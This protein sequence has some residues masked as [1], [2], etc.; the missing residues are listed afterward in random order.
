M[1]VI[2]DLKAPRIEGSLFTAVM[3]C[4]C[5]ARTPMLFA[6]SPGGVVHCPAC[7]SVFRVAE[8]HWTRNPVTGQ[9]T[10]EVPIDVGTREK[11]HEYANVAG[12]NRQWGD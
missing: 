8:V 7:N 11:P 2:I 12:D 6:G 5:P 1:A 3:I 10:L 4:P 9:L